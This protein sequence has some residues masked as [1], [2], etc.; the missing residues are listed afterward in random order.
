MTVKRKKSSLLRFSYENVHV[1]FH[2]LSDALELD[3]LSTL[4]KRKT[5]FATRKSGEVASILM[6]TFISQ[7]TEASRN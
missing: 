2:V 5:F 3:E 7:K 1:T 6:P 4:D